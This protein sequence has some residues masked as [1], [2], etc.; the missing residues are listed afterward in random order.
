MKLLYSDQAFIPI[1]VH[2]NKA[3]DKIIET[4]VNQWN[5]WP[6]NWTKQLNSMPTFL[7]LVYKDQPHEPSFLS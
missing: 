2:V 1:I 5:W 4:E 6:Q 7:W 3:P